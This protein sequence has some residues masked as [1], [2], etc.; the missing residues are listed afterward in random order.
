M[1][2]CN[3][4]PLMKKK[5]EQ[6][7]TLVVDRYAFSGVAFTSAKPVSLCVCLSVCLWPSSRLT[8]LRLLQ[9]FTLDWCKQPEVGLPKPDLVM[10]LKL[11]PADAALRGQFGQERYETSVFQQ[12][13]QHKFEQLMQDPTVN[14]QVRSRSDFKVGNV[15]EHLQGN[16]Q[17]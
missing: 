13:V 3:H 17:R 7:T 1:T 12:A 4:R 6:G 10:F 11:S 2:P 16:A 15:N 14:W 8:A 5:L 9:G